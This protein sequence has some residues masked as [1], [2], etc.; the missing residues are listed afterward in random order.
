MRLL[1]VLI[2]WLALAA[3]AFAHTA[4]RSFSAWTIEGARVEGVV[5]TDARR[6]TQLASVLPQTDYPALLAAHAADRVHVTQGGVRCSVAAPT[7]QPAEIGMVRVGLAFTC[8]RP[9]AE[10]ATTLEVRLF[11]GIS[12]GHIHYVRVDGAEPIEAAMSAATP[13]LALSGPAGPSSLIGF[14]VSGAEHV[15]SG[16]DHLAFL[17][18]LALLAGSIG[19]IAWAAT[20]FTLGHSIT[21]ALVT[22]GVVAPVESAVELLIGFTIAFAAAE[23]MGGGALRLRALAFA[24]FVLVTPLVAALIGFRPPPAAVYVGAAVFAACAALLG[25]ESSR[26]HATALAAVFGLVHGAGFA[27]A[28][29]VLKL[30]QDRIVPALFGFNVGVELGQ[31]IA[32][33][34]M[35]VAAALVARAPAP[36][37]A[38]T[39]DVAAAA[40]LGLG[41]FW[42]AERTFLSV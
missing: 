21:L 38:W 8:P 14:I 11:E 26:R 10:A 24:A 9:L 30:P 40:L 20:G 41:V 16:F 13:T 36:A 37:R 35:G 22:F 33:A 19:R 25:P 27:G 3:P 1:A 42:F 34:V 7:P 32:L 4:S 2:A 6:V 5:E 12:P 28:L 31:L 18:A 39:R 15:L 23:A 17:A 29:A